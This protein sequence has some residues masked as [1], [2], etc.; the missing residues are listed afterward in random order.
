M[1]KKLFTQKFDKA[2]DLCFGTAGVLHNIPMP[3]LLRSAITSFFE[4][5]DRSK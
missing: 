4:K 1:T 2:M 3:D 5:R